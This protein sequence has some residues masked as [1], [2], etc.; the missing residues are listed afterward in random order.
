LI[1]SEYSNNAL[2][3]Y[4]RIFDYDSDHQQKILVIHNVSEYEYQL[5]EVEGTVLYYSGGVNLYDGT[6]S[7]SSTLIIEVPFGE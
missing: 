3:S 6:I 2:M 7:S 4:Y 1:E 5:G